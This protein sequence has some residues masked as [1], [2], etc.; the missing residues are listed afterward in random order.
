MRL[1]AKT[2]LLES[3]GFFASVRAIFR[4]RYCG[5]IEFC[6]RLKGLKFGWFC[7]GVRS[8]GQ[9]RGCPLIQAFFIG[10]ELGHGS[11]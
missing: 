2:Y 6:F 11:R 10:F 5:L 4:A 3:R 7:G 8:L 1:I 9:V